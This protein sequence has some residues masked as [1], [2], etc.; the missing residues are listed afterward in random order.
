MEE[1]LEYAAHL[2]HFQSILM[3]FDL[4]AAPTELTMI[5]YFWEELKP[6]IKAE[7]D[8]RGRELESFEELV[9]RAV[10]AKAKAALQ[11][12]SYACET[13]YRCL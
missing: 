3:E 2:E 9:D 12:G 1:A 8:Q 10:K 11:L 7:I 4:M 13:D 6:L 5:W